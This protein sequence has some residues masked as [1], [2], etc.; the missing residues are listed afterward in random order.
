MVGALARSHSLFTQ[1]HL[2]RAFAGD[3][4]VVY[5]KRDFLFRTGVWRNTPQAPLGRL[6]HVSALVV[7]HSDIPLTGWQLKALRL[8][9]GRKLEIFASN[10]TRRGSQGHSIPI[11]LTNPTNEGPDHPVLGNQR[12]LEVALDQAPFSSIALYANFSVQSSLKHR[13][14]LSNLLKDL[15]QVRVSEVQKT[16]KGRIRYLKEMRR[17]G[18]VLCPRGKG[19]DT[20]RLFET[21]AV[22]AIPIIL[23]KD[24]PKWLEDFPDLPIIRLGSWTELM[25]LELEQFRNDD[26]AAI[27]DV[28]AADFW[29][30]RIQSFIE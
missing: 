22:G 11:G 29:V 10:L 26:S 18:F 28:L 14:P 4:R 27:F 12:H 9:Y 6:S 30:R 13:A 16:E 7:G 21:L 2:V 3:E 25:H 23:R 5:R 8:K 19:I 20:C 17:S 24:A 15:R 1:D